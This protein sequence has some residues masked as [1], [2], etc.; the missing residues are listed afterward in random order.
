MNKGMEY[1]FRDPELPMEARVKDLIGRLTLEEKCSL[2]RY[3]APAVERLGIPEY[4]WWSEALHGVGRAGKATV[5]PQAIG[6]AATFNRDLVETVA[7]AISDE[8]RAKHHEA[9][10]MGSRQQ[11]QGLTFWTPN[12]NIFRDP[13]WGRGQETWGEDPWYTG[14]MGAAFVRGLQ[15]NDPRYL[16]TAACAKHFAVHSGPEKDR[17]RFDARP[18]LKDFEETYLPAFKRLVDEGVESFMGAYN[19]VY[20]EPCC[21]SELLLKKILRGRWG[22]KGHVVSD[23]WAIKDFHND[24]KVTDSAEASAALAIKNGCDLNCGSV[25]CSSLF[26]AVK[27]GLCEEADV[28][29]ALGNLLRTLFKLGFFDPEERVPFASIPPERVNCEEH[30]Q[31]AL[32]SAL[33][34]VVLLKNKDQAL[35]IRP[36]DR[37]LLLMGPHA[38]SVEALMGNYF[39]LGTRM[40]T[41]LEGIAA[42]S[43][44]S[45]RLDYRKGCLMDR[46]KDNDMDW[47]FSEA[48]NGDIV[49]AAMGIDANVEGEEGDAIQSPHRGDRVD[50]R[51]PDHQVAFVRGLHEALQTREDPPRLV[52]LIFAGS[53]VSIP[54]IHD[55]ADAVMQVWYPGEAGGEAVA[56]LLF[57]KANPSGRMPISVPYR[58]ED[59]PPYE[60]Y[61]MAG[62]TYRFMDPDKVLYPFGFGLSYTRFTYAHLEVAE[63]AVKVGEAVDITVSVS[64]TGDKGGKE[65]VQVYIE[66]LEPVPCDPRLRLVACQKVN[67]APGAETNLTLEVPGTAFTRYRDEGENVPAPGPYRIHVGGSQ[68]GKRSLELGAAPCLSVDV[69]A[70]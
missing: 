23:C 49:I 66:P 42:E 10:R 35:P 67:L 55:Y 8:A 62:R 19:R 3:D 22:F 11:Y 5:F 31:L 27:L 30:R 37:Y 40:T 9:A 54:E 29:Q 33:E 36:S 61:A 59:L 13:R 46:P 6:L 15:G 41:L 4:N 64:N 69:V 44:A 47:A 53:H 17:H 1:P 52:V 48:K 57:G 26:D 20:G 56:K 28:D 38:A 63:P 16:K 68:P 70:G 7:S 18:P 60:E 51:L 24:H 39:G 50:T 32:E 12:I 58:V 21:G 14:E 65:V 25:Y 34:S 45:L 43:P 2:L